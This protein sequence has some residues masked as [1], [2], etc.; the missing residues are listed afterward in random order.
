M[1][2]RGYDTS[3]SKRRDIQYRLVFRDE[4]EDFQE[5]EGWI[6][7]T[8]VHAAYLVR[9]VPVPNEK[10]SI[11]DEGPALG[12]LMGPVVLPPD[13]IEDP[14]EDPTWLALEDRLGQKASDSASPLCEI[15]ID[16][17]KKGTLILDHKTRRG[18]VE[19]L[20]EIEEDDP[21]PTSD[22]IQEWIRSEFE[23][24]DQELWED[25]HAWNQREKILSL[26]DDEARLEAEAS[27]SCWDETPLGLV[28]DQGKV[29]L[30]KDCFSREWAIEIGSARSFYLDKP[31][32]EVF[33]FECEKGIVSIFSKAVLRQKLGL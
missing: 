1:R 9:L 14:S 17:A 24:G 15:D 7:G 22:T 31:D 27:L 18:W 2:Y 8:T 23:C 25:F 5:T 19:L 12:K 28:N 21:F 20:E 10:W 30:T 3:D 4:T 11:A 32:S 29:F 6:P 16:L 26:L 13:S 33:G